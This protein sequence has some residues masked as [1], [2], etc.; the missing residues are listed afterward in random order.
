MISTSLNR[1]FKTKITQINELP[2]LPEIARQLFQLQAHPNASVQQLVDIIEN[3]PVSSAQVLKYANSAFFNSGRKIESLNDA[4]NL[5]GFD[6]ALNCSLSLATARK[7]A[8][9]LAGPIGMRAFWKHAIYSA[10]LMQILAN[11]IPLEN[12]PKPGLAYLAGLLHNFG[13]LLL[14]HAFP[15]EFKQLNK[16]LEGLNEP[17]VLQMESNLLGIHHYQLAVWL[18]RKWGLPTEILAAVFE[19]HNAT[20]RG[21]YWEY[22]NLALLA[23]R[24]LFTHGIGDAD[25]EE[26]P[27]RILTALKIDHIVVQAATK[28]LWK[29]KERIDGLIEGLITP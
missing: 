7:F 13:Y 5:F 17:D 21:K 22:A 23:D 3:D 20:F 11:K 28:E 10:H 14:G 15:N 19:H 29:S 24:V 9:P 2:T 6:N 27:P 1:E 26:L 25:T 18:M 12:G 16:A 4:I 8:I